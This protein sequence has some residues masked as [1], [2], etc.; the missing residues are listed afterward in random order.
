MSV[1]QFK[2]KREKS[3]L[4]RQQTRL[5]QVVDVELPYIDTK[6]NREKSK[7]F[8]EKSRVKKN[9]DHG[10]DGEGDTSREKDSEQ[11]PPKPSESPHLQL[12]EIVIQAKIS[13]IK[14]RNLPPDRTFARQLTTLKFPTYR[15]GDREKRV[16]LK[17]WEADW[18]ADDGRNTFYVYFPGYIYTIL[19]AMSLVCYRKKL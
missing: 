10:S 14:R 3:K 2:F 18:K 13:E 1:K 11:G 19:T 7:L 5:W 4:Q 6:F 16:P 8:R 17:G 12:P 9:K 15:K